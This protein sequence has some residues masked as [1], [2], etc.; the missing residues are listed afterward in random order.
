MFWLIISSL[1]VIF[2]KYYTSVGSRKL[3]HRINKVK[4]DL[5]TTRRRLKEVRGEGYDIAQEEELAIQR[6]RYM[7]EMIDDLHLRI[8]MNSEE[9][10]SSLVIQK[11]LKAPSVIY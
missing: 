10:S 6:V 3:H 1:G 11:S 2:V 7:K 5:I 9:S 8:A 4:Y